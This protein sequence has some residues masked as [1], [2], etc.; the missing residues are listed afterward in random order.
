MTSAPNGLAGF[1]VTYQLANPEVA[2]ITDVQ[3]SGEYGITIQDIGENNNSVTVRA[4]DLQQN[5]EP[6]ATDVP[7]ATLQ[8]E[9]EQ[10]GESQI[11]VE[12]TN[13]DDDDGND[14]NPATD[15]GVIAVGDAQ[16]PTEQPPTEQPPTETPTEQ[17]PTEQPPTT[18]KPTQPGVDSD[19]DGLTDDR[20]RELGTDPHDCDTDGDG[21]EDGFEVDHGTSPTAGDTDGDGISDACE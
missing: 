5:Y 19:C 11:V 20:E 4:V 12:S 3:F 13:L 9:G 1:N 21:L 16:T 10:T 17:P 14:I 6:G 8:V 15:P 18:E 7:L 2:A